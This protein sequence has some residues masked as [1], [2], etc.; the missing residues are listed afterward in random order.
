MHFPVSISIEAT[1]DSA[2]HIEMSS[3][4]GQDPRI[5]LS[6]SFLR[7]IPWYPVQDTS[8]TWVRVL[9]RPPDTVFLPKMKFFNYEKLIYWNVTRNNNSGDKYKF[10][11][12]FILISNV[13]T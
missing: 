13:S 8:W 5:A 1:E 12:I 7:A 4:P 3:S 9:A 11:K 2:S 10:L 6:Q